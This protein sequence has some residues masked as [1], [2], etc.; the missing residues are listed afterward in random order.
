MTE[1]T[2][3]E[4]VLDF[5]LYPRTSVDSQHVG[6][7][8]EAAKAGCAFP[9][10]VADQKSKRVTDGFHRKRMYEAMYGPGHRVQV[11]LKR[12]KSEAEMFLDACRYNA[13]HGRALTTNDRTRCAILACRLRVDAKDLAG[14]L[15]VDPAT[16]DRLRVDRTAT[17]PNGKGVH[18]A[19]KRTIKHKAGGTLTKEQVAANDK[20]S[21]MSQTFYVNQVIILIESGLLNRDDE[22]LMQ[23]LAVLKGLLEGLGS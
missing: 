9:P 16:L 11:I 12:Y 19:L 7:M 3:S 18:V 20:L 23:R 6:Y 17:A 21:G 13:A 10:I 14:C 22:G 4:L 8:K 1:C 15:H 5:D 2:I